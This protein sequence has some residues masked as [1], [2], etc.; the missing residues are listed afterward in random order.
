MAQKYR[1]GQ[2]FGWDDALL[3]LEANDTLM[4]LKMKG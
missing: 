3:E 1:R 4:C 2:A